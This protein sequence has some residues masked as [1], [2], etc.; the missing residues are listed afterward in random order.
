MHGS[1]RTQKMNPVSAMMAKRQR[2]RTVSEDDTN[3]S[4]RS[5]NNSKPRNKRN[6]S[7]ARKLKESHYAYS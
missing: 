3:H 2:G 5:F 4:Q 1:F 7:S 6:Y